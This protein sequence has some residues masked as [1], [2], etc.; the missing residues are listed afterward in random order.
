LELKA[1]IDHVASMARK[2]GAAQN[3]ILS[4]VG[5]SVKNPII[6]ADGQSFEYTNYMLPMELDGSRVILAG[7]RESQ[8]VPFRYVRIPVDANDSVNEFMALRAALSEPAMVNLAATR[9]AEKNA[10]PNVDADL[11]QKAAAGAL[12]T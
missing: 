1:W 10:T 11:L 3:E 9:F 4:K 2:A 12:E 8:A 5:P 7:I 6:G